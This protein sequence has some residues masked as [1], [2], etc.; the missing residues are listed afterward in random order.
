[1]FLRHILDKI[2]T[3]FKQIYNNI[4]S[5]KWL[6]SRLYLDAIQMKPFLN[7]FWTHIWRSDSGWKCLVWLDPCR[8]PRWEWQEVKGEVMAVNEVDYTVVIMW[9]VEPEERKGRCEVNVVVRWCH[10]CCVCLLRDNH[11]PICSKLHYRCLLALCAAYSYTVGIFLGPIYSFA[12]VYT[13]K[14]VYS[15]AIYGV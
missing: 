5:K 15:T 13:K 4:Q 9:T 11:Y 10:A 8:V 1:M 7:K 2:Q 12:V 6:D 14:L 3:L